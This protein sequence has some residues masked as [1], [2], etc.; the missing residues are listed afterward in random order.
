MSGTLEVRSN[1]TAT[2]DWRGLWQVLALAL[3]PM[4]ALGFS[5]FAY[6][7][8]LP[9]MQ[10]DLGW[11]LSQAGA[12]NTANGAGYLVGALAAAPMARR[13]GTSRCFGVS[14]FASAAALLLGGLLHAWQLFMWVRVLGGVST[15]IIFVLG[16]ALA[17]Q[18]MPQ[19]PASALTLYFAGS[20]LGM[21]L[22][23]SV[24][25]RWLDASAA[26]WQSAWVILGGA[27]LLAALIGSL[28]A[29]SVRGVAIRSSSEPSHRGLR[30][31]WP[32]L[33][34][35]GLFGAGYVG[36]TTF[37]IALLRQQGHDSLATSLFFCGL[38]LASLAATS[39]WGQGLARLRN[40]QG[41]A[42]VCACVAI[43]TVP[44]LLSS[45]WP[46]L[47]LSALVFGASF[48]A[49]PA[50]VSLVAQR[51]LSE[52]HLAGALG[53]LTAS[54]SLGQ[55]LGPLAAGWVAD[56]TGQLAAGLWLGPVLLAGAAL[57][58]SAQR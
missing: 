17:T 24:L 46:A 20:G 49:G 42:L 1:A 30:N 29:R 47:A 19:R 37:V 33:V 48:M 34:A 40:G 25:P 3:A 15:A 50:A 9:A 10:G 55:A 52:R 13:W 44:V 35:N 43:G 5:R 26:G 18:A 57:V 56:A 6:A 8:L 21:V 11:S 54:F 4:V 45:A 23:G 41:F 51:L 58:S 53:A 2:P 38:G 39:G 16:T 7:L 32:I 36:Y 22:A 14:M 27:A 28:A 12:L 31:L